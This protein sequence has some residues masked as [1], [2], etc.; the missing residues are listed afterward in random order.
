MLE[1][2]LSSRETGTLDSY[3]ETCPLEP[4]MRKRR[5][6]MALVAARPICADTRKT[7]AETGAS[8]IVTPSPS[9]DHMPRRARKNARSACA[10]RNSATVDPRPSSASGK[11]MPIPSIRLAIPNTAAAAMSTDRP[12]AVPVPQ[13]EPW[14][15]TKA[16]PTHEIARKSRQRT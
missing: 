11:T 12:A 15:I 8:I 16:G 3:R 4:A 1:D 13:N 7:S 14:D 9:A 10:A 2:T 5:A 6:P